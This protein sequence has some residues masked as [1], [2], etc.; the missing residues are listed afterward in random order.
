MNTR[1][2][3]DFRL[4]VIMLLASVFLAFPAI[5]SAE[6]ILQ[7]MTTDGCGRVL[8]PRAEFQLWLLS[9]AFYVALPVALALEFA[10]PKAH[11]SAWVICAVPLSVYFLTAMTVGY[12]NDEFLRECDLLFPS[13]ATYIL[14]IFLGL[15]IAIGISVFRVMGR[16][17]PTL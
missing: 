3:N 14:L 9:R 7:L 6:I 8:H 17:R 2:G 13:A 16:R 1:A 4:P 12:L 11:F 10:R 15:I 5:P